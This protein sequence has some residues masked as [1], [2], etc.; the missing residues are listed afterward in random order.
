MNDPC[1]I[2]P[3]TSSV[4]TCRYLRPRSR[5]AS[6]S[7]CVPCMLVMMNAS[8]PWIERSTWVSAAKLTIA[9][10]P[11]AASADRRRILDRAVDEPD[12]VDYVVEVLPAPG[13]GE[14]VEHRDLVAVL[15]EPHPDERRADESGAAAYEQLHRRDHPDRHVLARVPVAS[16]GAPEPRARSAARC[17][18][19]VSP[20]AASRS[21]GHGPHLGRRARRRQRSR[22]RT[23][24]TSSGPRRR[25]AARPAG[26]SSHSSTS[27]AA[28][29]PVKVGQP[30]WSSTT[31]SSSRSAASLRIVGGEARA[32]R[33]EQPGRA[34]DRVRAGRGFGDRPLARE[35]RAAVGRRRV[36]R[37]G[38]DVRVALVPVEHV[39]AR[40]VDRPRA[41]RGGRARDVPG[42]GAVRGER[43]RL[44]RLGSVD[45]GPCRA[46]DDC[47]GRGARDQPV[48]GFCVGDI[49][50]GARERDRLEAGGGRGGGDILSEH[51]SRAG[52]Q[53]SHRR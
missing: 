29:W 35:L 22:R 8:G 33:T 50:L 40:D 16:R 3:Y 44:V 51:P 46:V 4:E 18:R 37:I 36:G 1:S 32:A 31:L 45:V 20:G 38:L 17:R 43:I 28:R 6:S 24:T 26:A 21:V 52:D 42:A 13:V 27:A 30:T 47:V 11:A 53:Q 9:S 15:A 19:G 10:Q 7:T 48:D 49:E 14:L 23:R 12:L 25:R 34:D 41:R 2:E 5:A 39:V